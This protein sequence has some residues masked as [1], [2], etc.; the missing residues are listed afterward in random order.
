LGGGSLS[1]LSGIPIAMEASGRLVRH[2]RD[3]NGA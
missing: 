2:R 3:R 1:E